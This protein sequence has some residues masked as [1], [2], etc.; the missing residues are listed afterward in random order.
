MVAKRVIVEGDPVKGTDTHGV[1]GMATVPPPT[2]STAYT[3][4]ATYSYDGTMTDALSDFVT[5]GGAPVATV[6]S[7]SALSSNHVAAD[8]GAPF[9]PPET[10]ALKPEPSTFQLT[11]TVLG[12]GTPSD[13]A[14]SS[15]VTIGVG[16]AK[17]AVLLHEDKINT[18]GDERGSK[19]STVESTV[20]SFVTVTE[21]P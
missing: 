2:G 10:P 15:F 13:G 9:N 21:E 20:Q 5:I 7:R 19:N 3:G 12:A 6:A 11:A 4:T 18:C 8:G 17:A 16:D 1:T 14:G